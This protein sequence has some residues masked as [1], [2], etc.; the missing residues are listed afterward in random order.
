MIRPTD[1]A[2]EPDL[3]GLTKAE[4][5]DRLHAAGRVST[6]AAAAD[7]EELITFRDR[8]SIGDIVVTSDALARENLIGCITGDYSFLGPSPVEDYHRIRSVEW[9]SRCRRDDLPEAM[10][11]ATRYRRTI[12]PLI[13]NE[14]GW[15]AVG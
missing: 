11:K 15:L 12:L 9:Y 7:V 1:A 6:A 8:V 5:L 3:R 2:Q 13:V 10:E 4:V 14:D